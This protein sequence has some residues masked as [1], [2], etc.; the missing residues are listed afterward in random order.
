MMERTEIEAAFDVA[1]D[2]D[3]EHR[4]AFLEEL[5]A[6]RPEV[7][8][9][10]ERLLR[11]H[12]RVGILDVVVNA[13]DIDRR[14]G[15]YRVLRELGRG[16]MGVVYLAERDDGHFERRVAVKLL[17]DS[18]D[19][20]ELH[21][22]FIAERQILALLDHPN[23]AQLI[24]GGVTGGR[25]PYLVMEYVDGLPITDYCDRHRLTV[26]E[27]LRLFLD[28]C[29]AVHHAHRN[30]IIHRD[31]KPGNILVTAQGQVKLLDFGIA[32]LLNPGLGAASS[33][34]TRHGRVLTPEYASPE[35]LAGE[36]LSTTSDVY[37]L[38]IVL[39]ELLTGAR[40]AAERHAPA[41][42][43]RVSAAE[44]SKELAAARR[45]TPEQLRR[46]L[47]G[48][49]D[50]ILGMALR[51]EPSRRYGS[52]EL[53]A[54]DIEHHL[55]DL[56][57]AA[58]HGNR[59]YHAGKFVRRHSLAAAAVLIGF[60]ALLTGS[61]IALRQGALARQESGRA[62]LE[63]DRAQQAMLDAQRITAFLISL[64]EVNDPY[65][66]QDHEVTASD[67]LRRG[68]QQAEGL[69]DQPLAQARLLQV[70]G[71]VQHARADY[72]EARILLERALS[73]REIQLG[74][75]HPDVAQTLALLAE[76]HRYASRYV[77]ADAAARRALSIR[78]D[79]YGPLHEE[80]GISLLQSATMAVYLADLER[81]VDLSRRSIAVLESTSSSDSLVAVAHQTLAA[82]LGRRAQFDEAET[83]LREAVAIARARGGETALL[84]M[85][86]MGLAYLLDDVPARTDEAEQLYR[87]GIAIRARVLGETHPLYVAALSDYAVYL[88][89]R[90]RPA[91]A[92]PYAERTWR[93]ANETYGPES[94]RTAESLGVYARAVFEAGQ[95]EEG[96]AL[97]R[98][99][100]DRRRAT[101][102]SQ[103]NSYAGGLM[104]LASLLHANGGMDEEAEAH[105]REAIDVIRRNSGGRETGLLAV[106]YSD[107]AAIQMSRE[108]YRDAEESLNHTFRIL[109]GQK[110]L[111]AHADYQTALRRAVQLYTATGRAAD[112]ARYRALLGGS[113]R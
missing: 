63:R 95:H 80:V 6:G 85:S 110:V 57:V 108:R 54:Q 107:L 87:E 49:I 44:V 2:L 48:D 112:A 30:L 53:M 32:K 35:Q 96:I 109:D 5:R 34:V 20:E 15:P 82:S 76:T 102:G 65:Q 93:T 43:P 26:A 31:L 51:E 90:N 25:L 98:E 38:G 21:H 39:F 101:L 94:P 62:Q 74:V 33:P 81:A 97:A 16:G 68:R 1:I 104:L 86:L 10:V 19:A 89:R 11:A 66:E 18:P 75:N 9:A 8:E 36:P 50:A 24:D 64:F 72:T 46:S 105:T 12:A 41:I 60:S 22:R 88:Q 78:I 14:I 23:I 27:R 73:I 3:A 99:S 37:S 7:A 59:W 91:E 77:E 79:A 42:S 71:R 58:Q 106:A 103:H 52:A 67:L 111:P 92:L 56:P 28:V 17:R 47:R 29:S 100:L 4:S 55:E 113:G 83:H 70:I 40:P 84:A 45:S 13:Q 61:M 69:S